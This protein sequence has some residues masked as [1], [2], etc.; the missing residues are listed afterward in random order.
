MPKILFEVLLG[1]TL[2]S[3]ECDPDNR[4]LLFT[5]VNNIKYRMFHDQQCCE[6]VYLSEIIGDLNDLIYSPIF[7]AEEVINKIDEPVKQDK[8]GT[9][10]FYKLATIKGNVTL[11]WY[12][13][14]NG[15][16]SE[17]VDF[18]IKDN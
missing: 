7:Q 15:Y 1:K 5:D 10:T 3:I 16:Y 11:R 18:E 4:E 13:E 8:Y 12:G 9:W 2:K 6:D 17:K 14:S